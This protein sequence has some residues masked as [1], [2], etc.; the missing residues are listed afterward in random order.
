MDLKISFERFLVLM[1]LERKTVL[2]Y[3]EKVKNRGI[4]KSRVDQ[5]SEKIKRE[6]H[7]L[8]GVN[9]DDVKE[10]IDQKNWR[11]NMQELWRGKDVC[12]SNGSCPAKRK[13]K[14][15][16]DSL[17]ESFLANFEESASLDKVDELDSELLPFSNN[18]CESTFSL[19]KVNRI[20]S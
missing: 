1:N 20:V 4:S 11:H 16:N 15:A 2:E 17:N 14:S 5:A 19:I 9:Y 12:L 10:N 18:R 8:F 13:R 7:R 3:A 6:F